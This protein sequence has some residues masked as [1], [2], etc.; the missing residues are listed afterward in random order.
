MFILSLSLKVRLPEQIHV[1]LKPSTSLP[2]LTTRPI[3]SESLFKH[4]L[5]TT[6]VLRREYLDRQC[7]AVEAL[8][9][10]LVMIQQEKEAQVLDFR[11]CCQLKE[12]ILS[13]LTNMRF[14]YDQVYE[15]QMDLSQRAESLVT[16]LSRVQPLLSESETKMKNQL[17]V[18]Q[19]NLDLYRSSLK[20]LNSRREYQMKVM[21]RPLTLVSQSP[22]PDTHS[23]QDNMFR[24]EV[25]EVKKSLQ[26]Q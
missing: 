3:T 17:L 9:K 26:V 15:K 19:K 4:T 21:S 16:S 5:E 1:I 23:P 25:K 13:N 24:Q 6:D 7:L 22:T 8:D 18:I 2:S 20:E 14:K 10:C 12:E 11:R